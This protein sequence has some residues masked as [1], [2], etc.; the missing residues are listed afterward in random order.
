MLFG[1]Q[2]NGGQTL[3]CKDQSV[4]HPHCYLQFSPILNKCITHV[5]LITG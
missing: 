1:G 3:G 4:P 5:E 2:T